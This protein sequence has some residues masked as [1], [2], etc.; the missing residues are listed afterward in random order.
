MPHHTT[1]CTTSPHTIPHHRSHHTSPHTTFHHTLYC[2]YTI[3]HHT[4]SHTTP[5]HPTHCTTAHTTSPHVTPH[6]TSHHTL[7]H[8]VPHH[9]K[10]KYINLRNP[11]QG[12][13]VRYTWRELRYLSWEEEQGFTSLPHDPVRP[14]AFGKKRSMQGLRL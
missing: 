4:T 6:H 7:P 8:T 11:T 14:Q 13:E 1:P 12:D 10:P 9:T 5:Y 2:I 3:P